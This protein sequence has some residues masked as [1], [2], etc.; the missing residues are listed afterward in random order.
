MII[1]VGNTLLG[2]S[3][4]SVLKMI[5]AMQIIIIFPLTEAIVPANAGEVL[6]RC[7]KVA[8]FDFIEIGEYV[9]EFLGLPPTDPVNEKYETLGI[10]SL[11]FINNVGTFITVML[12]YCLLIVLWLLISPL[13]A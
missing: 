7:A 13:A 11:Y 12:V 9:N 5:N 6:K 10:E 1:L 4:N 3:L 8:S 2:A